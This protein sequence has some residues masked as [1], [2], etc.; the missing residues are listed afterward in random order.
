MAAT[1][2]DLVARAKS[3][4]GKRALKYTLASVVSSVISVITFI[5]LKGIVRLD[6]VAA[7]IIAV[8]AGG[9]PN[10]YMNRKW[11][12]GKSGKS[13][14]WKE[15]V[16]FWVLAFLG[17]AISTFAVAWAD[18]FSTSHEYSHFMT[19]VVDTLANVGAFGVLWVGKYMIFNKLMFGIE[20]H[21]SAAES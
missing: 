2:S 21:R 11:A 13:H 15:I 1:I 19:T 9:I 5:I 7:N 6:A 3:P 8:V 14:L 20:H 17:L 4:E 16:P 12:W 10:Y 18:S